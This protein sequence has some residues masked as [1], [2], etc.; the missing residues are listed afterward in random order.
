[1]D[2]D[3]AHAP[4]T[5]ANFLSYVDAKAY[6]NTLI[7]RVV[8]QYCIQGGGYTADYA[9]D[10]S[11]GHTAIRDEARNGLR[12][13]KGTIA[14]ARTNDSDSATSQFFFNLVDNPDLDP[15]PN[16]DGYAVFGKVV[17]GQDVLDKIASV[18][19]TTRETNMGEMK[20]CPVENVV[21][22]SVVRK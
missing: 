22:N 10:I 3:Y 1:V 11:E 5:V 17:A 8:P 16:Q 13:T 2:L 15:S 6:N 18:Q 9:R 7:H 21:V 20:N 4:V 14:M 19:T 12:N